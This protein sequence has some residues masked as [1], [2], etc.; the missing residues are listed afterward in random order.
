GITV[1]IIGAPT[2]IVVIM[3]LICVV[4]LSKE[5]IRSWVMCTLTMAEN[6]KSWSGVATTTNIVVAMIVVEMMAR[7]PIG[8]PDSAISF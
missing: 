4:C 2:I 6:Q 7:H 3:V 8:M 1:H 5:M